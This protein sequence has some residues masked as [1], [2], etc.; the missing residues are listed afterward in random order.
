LYTNQRWIRYWKW[1]CK[2]AVGGDCPTTRKRKDR[3]SKG[4]EHGEKRPG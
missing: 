2:I 1:K 4:W 3:K